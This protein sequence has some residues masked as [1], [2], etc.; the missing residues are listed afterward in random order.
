MHHQNNII[1]AIDA[2]V[3]K[4]S[5]IG[6]IKCSLNGIIAGGAL[7]K[8]YARIGDIGILGI[9]AAA[10]QDNLATLSQVDS[11][12]IQQLATNIARI[13][14]KLILNINNIVLLNQLAI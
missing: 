4:S 3:G 7:N 8:G 14:S 2:C 6:K 12:F 11:S 10:Q 9:V 1:I 13:I 5:E